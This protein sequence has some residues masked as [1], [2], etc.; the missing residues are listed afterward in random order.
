MPVISNQVG[1]NMCDGGRH[2]CRAGLFVM[3]CIALEVIAVVQ[4]AT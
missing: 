1:R 3:V 2:V 4:Y